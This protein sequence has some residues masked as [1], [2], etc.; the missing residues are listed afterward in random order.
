MA[1]NVAYNTV[2]TGFEAK[3]VQQW[4]NSAGHKKNM[5]ADNNMAATAFLTT[6]GRNYGT[7]L[8]G[9]K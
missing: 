7:Q 1:E 2:K 3:M 6:N 5:L 8:F 9:K 4:I